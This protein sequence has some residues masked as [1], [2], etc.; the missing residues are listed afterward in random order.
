MKD[1]DLKIPFVGLAK[2]QET[3]VV[4][5]NDAFINISIPKDDEGLKLIIHLR[6]EAHRFAKNYHHLLR[7][8][9]LGV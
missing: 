6:D 5:Q 7:R 3:L 2:R 1:L 4:K 8:K 9:S